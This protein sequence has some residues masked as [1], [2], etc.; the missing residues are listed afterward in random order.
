MSRAP[1]EWDD[2]ALIY[3]YTVLCMSSPPSGV[4]TA[5]TTPACTGACS[6]WPDRAGCACAMTA[7]RTPHGDPISQM[8]S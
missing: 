7:R 5:C 6:C 8:P 2:D 1:I 3:D 4:S